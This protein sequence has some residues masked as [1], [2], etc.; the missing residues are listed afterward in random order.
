MR[1]ILFRGRLRKFIT[2]CEQLI[3][4]YIPKMLILE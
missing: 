1:E 2:F 3:E 4:V